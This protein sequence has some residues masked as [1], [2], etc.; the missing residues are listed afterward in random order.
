M[1]VAIEPSVELRHIATTWPASC[2]L[3]GGISYR[4]L[5]YKR[6]VEGEVLGSGIRATYG[7]ADVRLLVIRH[8]I[9]SALGLRIAGLPLVIDD[10]ITAAEWIDAVA[11]GVVSVSLGDDVAVLVKVPAGVWS[12]IRP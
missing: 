2:E 11:G 6:M 8:L 7:T 3:L 5:R 12:E 4:S 1:N 9:A 10:S